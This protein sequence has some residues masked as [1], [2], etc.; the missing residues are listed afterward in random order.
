MTQPDG[1]DPIEEHHDDL[2]PTERVVLRHIAR[3]ES[4]SQITDLEG[5]LTLT[6]VRSCLRRFRER[7]GLS[8]RAL[9]AWAVKHEECCIN[10]AG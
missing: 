3:G 2:T 9:D 1:V 7:T 5:D 4:D 10:A 8:G 6:A